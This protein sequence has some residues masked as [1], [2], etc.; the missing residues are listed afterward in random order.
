MQSL[1]VK[2]VEIKETSLLLKHCLFRCCLY[3]DRRFFTEGSFVFSFPCLRNYDSFKGRNEIAEFLKFLLSRRR[4]FW[5]FPAVKNSARFT[6]QTR[7]KRERVKCHLA[8][9]QLPGVAMQD[10]RSMKSLTQFH[11]RKSTGIYDIS[12]LKLK[13]RL[14]TEILSDFGCF[15]IVHYATSWYSITPRYCPNTHLW[16]N[17]IFQCW[18]DECITQPLGDFSVPWWKWFDVNVGSFDPRNATFSLYISFPCSSFSNPRLIVAEDVVPSHSSIN[19]PA[20]QLTGISMRF[21]AVASKER[22]E[23]YCFDLL[24]SLHTRYRA[25]YLERSTEGSGRVAKP[26]SFNPPIR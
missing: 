6:S 9:R 8:D 3:T 19:R 23:I 26:A 20:E 15:Q 24:C 10:I 4:N 13:L 16:C 14:S 12:K 21:R 1:H 22:V 11:D 17:W 5:E 18:N 25:F 7:Y 2:K